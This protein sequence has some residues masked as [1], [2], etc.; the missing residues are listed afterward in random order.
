MS[1]SLAY[2][3]VALSRYL[4]VEG[5]S[6]FAKAILSRLCLPSQFE[7]KDAKDSTA[8]NIFDPHAL[9]AEVK[10]SLQSLVDSFQSGDPVHAMLQRRLLGSDVPNV[11][12]IYHR[13]SARLAMGTPAQ[14]LIPL[15][16]ESV[17]GQRQVDEEKKE[18]KKYAITAVHGYFHD[19]RNIMSVALS[20][21]GFLLIQLER[22]DYFV[23][24]AEICGHLRFFSLFLTDLKHK[25][26]F[27]SYTLDRVSGHYED[28]DW[29]QECLQDFSNQAFIAETIEPLRE[30]S[31]LISDLIGDYMAEDDDNFNDYI[32]SSAW[33]DR[34]E[35]YLE[36]TKFVLIGGREPAPVDLGR[37]IETEDIY[38]ILSDY[39]VS[40]DGSV[41]HY[42]GIVRGSETDVVSM[43]SN[44]V[45]NACQA[46]KDRPE[47]RIRI[48]LTEMYLSERD[49][50][51]YVN[52]DS[53]FIHGQLEIGS[54]R[55]VEVENRG[56]F[57]DQ[58]WS[59]MRQSGISTK[60]T[61]GLGLTS[62][63]NLMDKRP[64]DALVIRRKGGS[65]ITELYLR[66]FH[67]STAKPPKFG[68]V[69]SG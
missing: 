41:G 21:A 15:S 19:V 18:E 42:R 35:Q 37:C 55:V 48:D 61:S 53:L 51:E 57:S 43:V 30:S 11:S 20:A 32:R 56:K 50:L 66:Q 23:N 10:R 13:P 12:Q 3:L 59:R 28:S 69:V 25:M 7:P 9:H 45:R 34:I 58:K 40:R 17:E 2:K 47:K 22:E 5:P 6:L 31:R 65:V 68:K 27:L 39:R 4:D 54:Y 64:G 8:R 38:R 44:L 16:V 62:L 52:S 49:I 1:R 60:G 29:R 63:M 24:Q 33:I 14:S 46:V 36:A 26:I 67:G